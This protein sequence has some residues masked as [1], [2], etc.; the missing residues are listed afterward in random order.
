MDSGDGEC[1]S[2]SRMPEVRSEKQR[3]LARGRSA[4]NGLN[5]ALIVSILFV[6][7][8]PFVLV[9]SYIIAAGLTELARAGSQIL[10]SFVWIGHR[11]NVTRDVLFHNGSRTSDWSL[12]LRL[13]PWTVSLLSAGTAILLWGMSS[14][15]TANLLARIGAQPARSVGPGGKAARTLAAL[16]SSAGLAT[17]KLYIVQCSFP[18]VFSD[19]TSLR[20]ALVAVTTGALDLLEDRE[21]EALLAHELSHIANHDGRLEAILASLAEITEFPSRILQRKSSELYGKVSWTRNL[22]LVEVLLSPLSLYIFFISPFLNGL[23]R[24]MVLRSREF[25]ADTEAALLTAD[26]EGLGNA[27]AKIGGVVTVLGVSTVSSLPAHSSLSQRIERIMELWGTCRF[28][29]LEQA[30]A[31]GKQYARERPGMGQ[32]QPWLLGP[33]S[34]LA[35]L[36]PGRVYQ[37]VSSEATPLFD[38]PGPGALV[39]R[40]IEPGALLVVFDAQGKMHQVNTAEEVFG[41]VSRKVKLRAVEGVLPQEVYE[42][43]ARAAIEEVLRREELAPRKTSGAVP[44]IGLTSRQ[45]WIAL[46]FGAAVF[47]GTTVLLFVFAGR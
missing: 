23:I 6:V 20:H 24:A 27:L 8:A 28:N 36:T 34:Q 41:Y 10:A 21:M 44:L 38:R 3:L 22:A 19:A 45:L 7:L 18:T 32:D 30:I 12:I 13:M 33:L 15:A 37:F 42:P 16:S 31:K 35:N 26:P 47:A 2:S 5:R 17:P 14:A 9:L 40:R 4:R 29:G 46:G 39:R 1:Y 25:N 43:E 11:G